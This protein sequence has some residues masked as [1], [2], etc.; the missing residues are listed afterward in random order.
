M[1]FNIL[2][3]IQSAEPHEDEEC[4]YYSI[5]ELL[6]LQTT[7]KEVWQLKSL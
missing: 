7:F 2:R 6:E 4:K 1:Y 3:K 5:T